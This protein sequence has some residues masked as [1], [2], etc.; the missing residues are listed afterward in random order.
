MIQ[1]IFLLLGV[2]FLSS[3]AELQKAA[4]DAMA[5]APLSEMEV[6][7][8]LKEALNNGISRGVDVLSK[9][10]GYYKSPYKILLPTEVRKVTDKLKNIPGFTQVEEAL[11]EKINRGAEDAATRAKPIFVNAIKQMTIKDAMKILMGS[12]N[13]ATSY[14][15]G[16]TFEKLYA[17]FNPVIVQ[18]LSKVGAT[19]YWS[20]AVN[21]YNK[22]PLITKMNP[23]LD[24]YVTRQAL[25]GLFNM[26][27]KEEY[28][29]RH[30][31]GKRTTDL[32][33]R[34]FAKQDK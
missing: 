13:S 10:D 21:T 15:R 34:V 9:A 5:N 29:I 7:N 17:E 16:A 26:I 22:I 24:D 14:L 8:G 28:D 3:C 2:V 18:S 33:R 19:K 1:R 30:N 27:E 31:K 4:T 23:D 11:L 32:L 6:G 25:D 12:D 20:D